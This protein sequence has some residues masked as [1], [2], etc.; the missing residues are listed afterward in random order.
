MSTGAY[1]D[2]MDIDET[3][4]LANKM[5]EITINLIPLS[6]SLHM[7]AANISPGVSETLNCDGEKSTK[8][9]C[10]LLLSCL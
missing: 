5:S 3:G 1:L 7:S 8:I 2:E 4:A 10:E 6:S 9:P